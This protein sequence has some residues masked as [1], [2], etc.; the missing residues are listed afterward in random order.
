MT[1]VDV[2]KKWF[3]HSYSENKKDII[4]RNH[5]LNCLSEYGC[6]TEP[7]CDHSPLYEIFSFDRYFDKKQYDFIAIGCSVTSGV[8]LKVNETWP[9]FLTNCKN[10]AIPG[11]GIDAIWHNLKFLVNQNKVKFKKFVILL[12]DMQRKV[13]RI[14]RKNLYFNFI[15][16]PFSEIDLRPNFAFKPKEMTDLAKIHK[17]FLV[18]KG[19]QY[20]QRIFDRFIRWLKKQ[21]IDF[22]I[23]S[24]D[25]LTYKSLKE[26]FQNP[27]LLP[28]FNVKY[29]SNPDIKHPSKY[30]HQK[31]FEQIRH[32]I[33]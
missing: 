18:L 12:P 28:R 9:N 6:G 13:F 11:I 27:Q 32:Y 19:S 31:W 20:G 16:T 2:R 23:S 1:D 21:E 5:N 25:N 22:H 33:L 3:P 24:W 10:F 29:K 15:S 8:E 17:K 7:D 4:F 26:N 30:A 14:Y